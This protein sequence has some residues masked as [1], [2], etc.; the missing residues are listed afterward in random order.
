MY[1]RILSI[2]N[3]F[4]AIAYPALLRVAVEA[5]SCT[6][7]IDGIQYLYAD[8]N[9]QC[10]SNDKNLGYVFAFGVATLVYPFGIFFFCHY[11][12]NKVSKN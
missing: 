12:C 6:S 10:F 8:F 2:Y 7:P 5:F 11:L 9:I 1:V 3:R 4:I